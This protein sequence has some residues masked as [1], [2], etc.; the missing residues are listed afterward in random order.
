MDLTKPKSA[1]EPMMPYAMIGASYLQ[2]P[3]GT[4]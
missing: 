1:V 4:G 2:E 3:G